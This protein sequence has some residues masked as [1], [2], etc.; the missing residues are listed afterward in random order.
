VNRGRVNYAEY[1]EQTPVKEDCK[2][3]PHPDHETETILRCGTITGSAPLFGGAAVGDAVG[4]NGY[5]PH[6]NV[7]ATVALDTSHL[8]DSTVK[9][10]FSSLISYRTCGDDNYFLH[11]SFKLSKL[12]GG[13]PIP[14]GNWTFEQIHHENEA[15]PMQIDGEFVQETVSYGFTWCGCDGCPD[16]CRYIVEIIDQQCYNIEFA[17]VS[18]I[19][20]TALAVG[21]K[22]PHK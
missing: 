3:K 14:L 15:A 18:N 1:E 22:N 11:L 21:F 6:P 4:N 20:L 2:C 17:A 7:L 16:C 8:I 12:C 19:S 9:I 13:S 5:G 10:D